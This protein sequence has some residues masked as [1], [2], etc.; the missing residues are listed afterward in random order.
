[1]QGVDA[2]YKSCTLR[3]DQVL[4]I[5]PAADTATQFPVT[6]QSNLGDLAYV[7]EMGI[8]TVLCAWLCCNVTQAGRRLCR[9]HVLRQTH[10]ES[11]CRPQGPSSLVRQH[12]MHTARS[13]TQAQSQ[14][15][16]DR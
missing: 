9:M 14:V 16:R 8:E 12:A 2:G 11:G 6:C 4:D 7:T 5:R 1:M 13:Y 15:R 3:E 10:H